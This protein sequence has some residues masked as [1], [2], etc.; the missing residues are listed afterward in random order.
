MPFYSSFSCSFSSLKTKKKKSSVSSVYFYDICVITSFLYN[1]KEQ[2]SKVV[3]SKEAALEK[4]DIW[5]HH[6]NNEMRKDSEHCQAELK[7]TI[8]VT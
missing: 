6:L 1:A 8:K 2:D 5:N 7:T 3:K 4:L